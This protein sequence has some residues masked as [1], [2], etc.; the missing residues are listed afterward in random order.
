MKPYAAYT[1][2]PADSKKFCDFL[3]SVWFP[4]GFASNLRKNVID[5]NNKITRLKSHDCYV[6][7][8]QVVANWD[9]TIHEERN[10]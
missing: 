10:C 2:T 6:I 3:K 5:G 9:S 1:L 8:Q 4:D 7:I